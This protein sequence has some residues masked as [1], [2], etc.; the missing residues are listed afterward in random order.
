M[1]LIDI[2]VLCGLTYSIV[3]NIIKAKNSKV[4]VNTLIGKTNVTFITYTETEY[5]PPVYVNQ[6]EGGV[7]FPVGGGTKKVEKDLLLFLNNNGENIYVDD[8]TIE[9]EKLQYNISYINSQS[10]LNKFCKTKNID[11]SSFP[12][13]FPLKIYNREF[14]QPIYYNKNYFDINKRNVINHTKFKNRLPLSISILACTSI[15]ITF[16]WLEYM[17]S[18]KRM[19]AKKPI[20]H[21]LRY[22]EMYK[23]L[24]IK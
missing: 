14:I 22:S 7:S 17:N 6:K 1:V 23:D 21:P 5:T 24:F 9:V 10:K 3:G 20:F 15:V 4:P 18:Y 12:I 2:T 11:E 19:Y 16:S 13:N 8:G